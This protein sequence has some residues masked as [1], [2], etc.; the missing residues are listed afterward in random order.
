M[1]ETNILAQIITGRVEP[2]IYAF[3]TQTVPNYLKIGDTYRP[4]EQRLNE[5]R[6]YFPNLEKCFSDIAKVNEETYFRDLAIHYYLQNE[7]HLLRLMP[8]TIK[9]LPHYS[10]EFFKNATKQDVEEAIK[11]I[12]KSFLSNNGIY[13]FY[14]FNESRIPINYVYQRTET[15]SPRPN[16]QATI[17][18]FIKAV[19]DKRNNLLMYA[20]MRFGKSFT[21]MCCA[22]EMNAKLVLVVSGKGDVKEEW[23]KTVESHKKFKDYVF[24]D[25]NSLINSNDALSQELKKNNVVV[26]LTLQDLR[27]DD[28]KTKHKEIF[29]NEFDLLIIDETHYGA[30]ASE[31]G[32]VLNLTKAQINNE[33]AETDTADNYDDNETLKTLQARVRLHLSGTPYRILMGSEF[34]PDDIIAFYQFTDIANDKASW[35]EKNLADDD[36]KEWDNPYYGFPQMIRF[37]F[38]PNE[39]SLKKMDELRHNG[40]TYAFS[41]LFRPCSISK[42]TS[43]KHNHKKFI[44]EPEILDLLE[45]IDG[46]KEDK[47]ILSFLDYDKIKDGKMCRHIVCV[48]PYRAS[49]DAFEQLIA[50]NKDKFKN[51]SQYQIINITGVENEHLFKDI[52]AVKNKISEAEAQNQKTMTLTV[53]KMLTGSTVEQW[54]TMIYLKDTESPQEYDQAIFRLQNQYIREYTDSRGDVIKYNMKPQTLLVDFNPA[55]MFRLQEQKSQI[56]NANIEKNG[57]SKLDDRISEELNISPIIWLNKNKMQEVIPSDIM[58]AVSKYSAEK[59]IMDE[60]TDIPAD[61]SLLNDERIRDVISSLSPID[62]KKGIEA[63]PVKGDG[64]NM[65][66]P[67]P[68]ESPSVTPDNADADK[69]NNSQD[70]KEDN[71]LEKK[72]ATYYA[73]I[74]FFAFLTDSEVISLENIINVFNAND[75]NKRIACNIG[76]SLNI[77]K[78]I[79]EKAN[80]FM[81]SKLDYKVQNI[82]TLK[83]DT[84]LEPNER[85]KKA[86][87][88]FGRLSS[89]EIV[90]PA[91]IAEEMIDVLPQDEITENTKF[92]DIASKQGEFTLA[93]YSKFGDKIKNNIYAIPTSTLTYEFTR[94][95]YT[96]LGMPIENIFSDFN[97]YELIDSNHNQEITKRLLDMKINAIVGNPP[98]NKLNGGGN[99]TSGEVLYN[100][101]VQIA[102]ET[103]ASYVSMIMPARWYT[104]GELEYIRKELLYDNKIEFLNDYPNASDCFSNVE[105]KGGI[106]HFL[107]NKN[108]NDK[109]NVYT[110]L[111]NSSIEKTKRNLLETNLS[112]FM[113]YVQMVPILQKVLSFKENSFSDIISANDPFGFDVREKGSYKR[114]KPSFNTIPKENSISFYYYRWQSKGV[115][116]VDRSVIRKNKN[117]V[118]SYK[119][120]IPKAWGTGNTTTDKLNAFIPDLHSCCTET[121]LVIG[122]FKT[123]QEATNVVSY[124]STK[125]FKLMVFVLK[126]T[127]NAMQDT[128]KYVPLQDFTSKS[129][130]DWS[131]SVSEIDNQLYAKYGLSEEEISFIESTIKE[132]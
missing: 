34:T 24:F 115:G 33:L 95:V 7:K 51:I 118:D 74:L 21:S 103:K 105:I 119:V 43:S 56:Y 114:V 109:C 28:I 22:V 128:Y 101:F 30:R 19:N 16:Q 11:D 124:I 39:S 88:K 63:K 14:S 44:H 50:D 130:I 36:V 72:L 35:D 113:R 61:L 73:K 132:M 75:D 68:E 90:T 70:E 46:S 67:L 100:K 49:C 69:N 20:V 40:I 71:S 38:N 1:I 131:K 2:Q 117:W 123:R 17:D 99:G 6:K 29:A 41:E 27:G 31:Y 120:F 13:Q 54:D 3:S 18:K 15:Y 23:K 104:S 107:W 106:C 94:K 59:S 98:Y 9:D 8:D 76:L 57:N 83:K 45:V 110:H 92:L 102:K 87:N 84:E 4:L 116:Y 66:V 121:Y 79:Q 122:P 60:A 42:D 62:S 25:S 81:L 127:Q 97:S 5:W 12:K 108:Y 80:P 126:L 82:D 64:D 47:N 77:L 32:K 129:D 111:N 93:L 48:L 89:S 26:F 52:T 85:V 37:A 96:L 86:M 10:K 65:E 58:A 112:I 78:I 125:F 91:K 53:N 55:R